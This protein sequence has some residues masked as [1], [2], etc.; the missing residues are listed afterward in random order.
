MLLFSSFCLIVICS[1]GQFLRRENGAER[2]SG[3]V[4]ILSSSYL[5]DNL[6]NIRD[7]L[8]LLS[9]SQLQNIA[10]IHGGDVT[11]VCVVIGVNVTRD[12]GLSHEGHL[13]ACISAR[14]RPP[15]LR[16]AQPVSLRLGRRLAAEAKVTGGTQQGWEVRVSHR[17]RHLWEEQ[18]QV[19]IGS[20]SPFCWSP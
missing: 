8:G 14:L 19:L 18:D 20:Q 15:A 5:Q 12:F 7:V 9:L 4:F 3:G 16:T 11:E 10:N 13:P 2:G 1:L 6:Q 17:Q